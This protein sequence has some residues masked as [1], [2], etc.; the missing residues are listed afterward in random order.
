METVSNQPN[1]IWIDSTYVQTPGSYHWHHRVLIGHDVAT[2]WVRPADRGFSIE[3]DGPDART[4]ARAIQAVASNPCATDANW[5][6]T[7]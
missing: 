4:A 6:V 3:C 5:S 2:V 7:A 1:T